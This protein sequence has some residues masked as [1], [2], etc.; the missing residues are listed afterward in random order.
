VQYPWNAPSPRPALAGFA[1][2]YLVP[3]RIADAR[4]LLLALVPRLREG[5]LP[6]EFPEDGSEPVYAGADVALWFVNAVYQYLAYTGDAPTVRRHPLESVYAIIDHYRRGTDLGIRTDDDGLL[7]SGVAGQGVTWMD[8]KSGDWVATPRLGRAVEVNALWYN[9]L[10]VAAE[11]ARRFEGPDR[12]DRSADYAALARSAREAFN[13]RFW[14]DAAGCC[15]D[16][17]GDQDGSTDASIRPNQLL[18]ISLPFAV[19]S[20][21]RHGR[22]VERVRQELLTPVGVR[23]LAPSDPHYHGRYEGDA[24]ARDRAYHNGPGF[25]WLLGPLVTAV[26]RTF[27]RGPAVL[28]QARAILGPS[29]DRLR[30]DGLGHLHEL[31]DGDAPHAPG[32]ATTAPL[33]VAEILRCYAEDLL[34]RNPALPPRPP[35]GDAAPQSPSQPVPPDVMHPA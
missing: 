22:V 26:V 34:G 19:L 21:D 25:P 16:V 17:L 18:A 30:G 32:G 11:L 31:F 6:T 8:A 33:A 5:L 1:G 23:T 24:H 4:S 15:Y 13:R 29:L 9:A 7:A 10:C 20:P 3:N 2:L 35:A 14:N 12:V 28:E 27:G